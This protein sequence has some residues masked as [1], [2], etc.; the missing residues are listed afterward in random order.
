M[1][2]LFYLLFLVLFS[3]TMF[4]QS[5]LTL[6][7]GDIEQKHYLQKIPYRKI[8]EKLIVDISINGKTY[9]FLFDTGAPFSISNKLYKELNPQT[10]SMG[11]FHDS[12]GAEDSAVVISI[13]K[14]EIGGL[15]FINTMGAILP[16]ASTKMLD[17]FGISGIIGSN[18]LRNSIVQFDDKNSQIIITD[19][20][21]NLSLKRTPYQDMKL[22]PVQ[23][24]PYIEVILKKGKEKAGG[25]VLFDC[26]AD[27][28]FRMSKGMYKWLQGRPNVMDSIAAGKGSFDWSV[29]GF[30][31]HQQQF[32][33]SIPEFVVNDFR[34]N[35]VFVMTTSGDESLIGA[36]L[37]EYGKATLDYRNRRFYFEP[38]ENINTSKLSE[39]EWNV[40]V[41]LKDEKLVV[42]LI[43]DKALADRINLGDEVLKVGDDDYRNMSFCN[44]M[45]GEDKQFGATEKKITMELKDVKTGAIK[46]VEIN[47]L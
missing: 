24:S 40:E 11:K 35:N 9:H 12:S 46:T 41:I 29:Y 2:K 33:L 16:E 26:G 38:Y 47:R 25:P 4:A 39:R 3:A 18:M 31:E 34:F 28:F 32:A 8:K 42:G 17:C 23:S 22:S 37:L 30:V 5:Q 36:R 14:L 10:I 13:P 21:K 27:G 45:L 7:G 1:N 6:N 20:S 19:N 15:G 44:L 43:W